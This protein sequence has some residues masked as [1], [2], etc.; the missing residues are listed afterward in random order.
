MKVKEY[1]TKYE[2]MAWS[3]VVSSIPENRT[4][5]NASGIFQNFNVAFEEVFRTQYLWVVPDPKLR[6]EIGA[7]LDLNVVYK[8]REFYVK[9]RVGLDSVIRYSPEDLRNYLSEILCGSVSS[10]SPDR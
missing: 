2:R 1:V 4:A 7:W 9:Y 8:Y 6:E 5:E 10:H 3:K